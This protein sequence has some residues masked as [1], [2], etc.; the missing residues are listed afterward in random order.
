VRYVD[1]ERL[2]GLKVDDELERSRLRHRQIPWLV[3]IEDAGSIEPGRMIA[4]GE[5]QVE[6]PAPALWVF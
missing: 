5:H 1:A 6:F 4:E 2:G 3:A